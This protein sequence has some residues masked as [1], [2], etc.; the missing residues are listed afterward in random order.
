MKIGLLQGAPCNG[1]HC[2]MRKQIN[3]K[4]YVQMEKEV[5]S[6]QK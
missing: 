2:E 1:S 6:K 5:N 3:R 4:R